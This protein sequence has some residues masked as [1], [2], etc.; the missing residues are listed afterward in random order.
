MGM[1]LAAGAKGGTPPFKEGE[2]IDLRI[3]HWSLWGPRRSGMYET[4]RELIAAENQ[5]EGV[6]AGMLVVPPEGSMQREKNA[7]FQGGLV[8]GIHPELRTQDWGWAYKFADVH[9]IHYSFDLKLGRLKP[10]VFFAHGTP[11][12]V[13]DS[14]LREPQKRA[15][16]AGAQ[17]IDKFEATIVT[18]QRAKQFW[19]VF[20]STDGKK[21]NVVSKGIDLEWWQ[22]SSTKA[23]LPGEPSVLYGEVWRGIKHPTSLLFA[24]N[25]IYKD[26]PEIRLNAWSLDHGRNFWENLIAQAGFKKFLG[27]DNIPGVQDYPEHFYS[28]GDV[29][30]SPVQAGDL[31]RVSQE[32]MACGC[33]VVSWDTDPWS[34]NY[35][36]KAAKGFDILDMASKIEATYEEILDDPESVAAKCRAIAEKYYNIHD[37]AKSVVEI[38]RK[39]V[40][41]Q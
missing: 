31:S 36:Y 4:V 33:P 8:D 6:L 12:A 16:L 5:I 34:E 32:A 14:G 11:E 17:W 39:V 29:L 9:V 27:Q 21:I 41:E 23:D 26:N 15:L 18:S 19:S 22:K 38:L 13:I 25:E 24:V 40:S 37:E 20:D 28:R 30:V 10:K 2:N 7:H 3:A 1:K 35:P